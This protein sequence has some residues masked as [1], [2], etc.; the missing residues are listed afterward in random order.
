MFV[1]NKGYIEVIPQVNADY[2][3]FSI[4]LLYIT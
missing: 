1:E 2:N 4:K 3:I